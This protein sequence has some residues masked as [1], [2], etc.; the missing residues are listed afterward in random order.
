M[1]MSMW[2]HYFNHSSLLIE[3]EITTVRN[4]RTI[5]S[6]EKK[7]LTPPYRTQSSQQSKNELLC[8]SFTHFGPTAPASQGALSSTKEKEWGGPLLRL[9]LSD[10]EG[11][12]A[13]IRHTLTL[14]LLLFHNRSPGPQ[15][16]ERKESTDNPVG[17]ITTQRSSS[18]ETLPRVL[19]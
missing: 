13:P 6:P 7:P 12:P 10:L 14:T 5:G 11:K 4:G 17:K 1:S 19:R 15:T 9:S 8:A 16:Q 18:V 3:K 2:E